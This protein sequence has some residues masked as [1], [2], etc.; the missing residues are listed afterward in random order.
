M[1]TNTPQDTTLT[2]NSANPGQSTFSPSGPFSLEDGDQLIVRFS[3]FPAGST[4]TQVKLQ[5]AS[6]PSVTITF[7]PQA[8]P[9]GIYNLSASSSASPLPA[10]NLR[11][12]ITDA[13]D[14]QSDEDYELSISGNLAGGGTWGADPEV[15]NKAGGG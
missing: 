13:E 6:N 10:P 2:F 3:G 1:P 8:G 4:V 14:P 15:I 5:S 9:S 11:V 12:T 7:P